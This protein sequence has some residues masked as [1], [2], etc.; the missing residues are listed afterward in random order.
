MR[1]AFRDRFARLLWVSQQ[2]SRLPRLQEAEAT[3]CGGLV[4]ECEVHDAL[5]LVRLIKSPGLDG[6]PYEVYFRMSY[7]F[8]PVLMGMFNHWLAHWAT[9]GTI[10]K[11]MITL[12]KKGGRQ[13]LEKLDNYRPITLLNIELKILV[14]VNWLQLVVS[15]LIGPVQNYAMKG[16]SVQDNLHFIWGILEE[17]EDDAE[18]ALIS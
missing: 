3:G 15:D 10:I 4:T 14:L 11:E 17:I 9:P 16:S 1:E 12:L 18:D 7:M 13:F 8:V 2:F 6:L 5:K